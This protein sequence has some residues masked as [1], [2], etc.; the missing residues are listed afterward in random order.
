MRNVRGQVIFFVE[1][2][3]TLTGELQEFKKGAFHF[4]V[5]NHLPVL[6]TAIRGSFTALAKRP[7][8][9]LQP[10]NEI[11]VLFCGPIDPPAVGAHGEAVES[12]RG[13][14]A[15]CRRGRARGGLARGSNAGGRRRRAETAEE[16][17][18]LRV[19]SAPSAASAF[20]PRATFTTTARARPPAH[21]IS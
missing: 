2:T 10:G 12:L 9:R 4:A 11:E 13:G 17:Q 5:G 20:E 14:D 21:S 15:R 6:P 16:T 7:W 3:R 18:R 19:P 1:G 8:W